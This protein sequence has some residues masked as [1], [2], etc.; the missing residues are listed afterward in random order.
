M[1]LKRKYEATQ[2]STLHDLIT[3]REW[4]FSMQHRLH[5]QNMFKNLP[6][7]LLTEAQKER[8]SA[9]Q[10]FLSKYQYHTL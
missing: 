9:T 10:E 8:Y 2:L 4:R 5:H 1:F 3:D 6:L 7:F